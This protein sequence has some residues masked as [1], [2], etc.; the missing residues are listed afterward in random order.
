MTRRTTHAC[1]ALIAAV[2]LVARLG[3]AVHLKAWRSPAAVENR[4]IAAALVGGKGFTNADW[5]YYGPTSAQ[6]PPFPLMLAGLFKATGAVSLD[7]KG[8]VVVDEARAQRAYM[9]VMVLNA[10]AGAGLVWLTYG[11]ARAVGASPVAAVVAGA[12]VAVWPTQ[13]YAAQLVQSVVL[14]TC[15]LMTMV[16]L[17]YRS[18]RTGGAGAWTAFAFVGALVALTEPVFLPPLLLTGLLV[19]L[20]RQLTVVQRLRNVAILA[21]SLVVAVGPWVVRNEIVGGHVTVLK[22]SFWVSVWKGNNDFATGTDRLKLTD[23]AKRRLATGAADEKEESSRQDDMLD[24][25]KKQRVSNRPEAF[26]EQVFR[27]W[28]LDWIR[29]HPGRYAQLC[30]IRLAKTLTVDWDNPRSLSKAYVAMRA[31]LGLM[32]LAG[33]VVAWRQRW[34]V[35]L[36][37][38]LAGSA[39]L[40]YT[41]TMTTVRYALPFE[42]MQLVLGAAAATGLPRRRRVSAPIPQAPATTDSTRVE[43][44]VAVVG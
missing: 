23:R 39:L 12:M 4:N 43:R 1:L 42:P 34:T 15:G 31:A 5:N 33:L 37:T 7:A 25:S 16:M 18:V 28:A 32:T 10:L 29:N 3:L 41:L 21:F 22:G 17:Y 11:A 19:L 38:L 30:G 44:R 9:A 2:A 40:A 8:S 14:V 13:V 27:E 36:P 24:I 26:R 6:S 35:L 20:A